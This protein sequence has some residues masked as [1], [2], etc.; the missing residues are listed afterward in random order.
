MLQRRSPKLLALTLA[1][2]SFACSATG[3]RGASYVIVDTAR[4]ERV[5]FDAF[6]DRIAGADVLFLGEQHDNRTCHELQHWTTIA[7]AKRKPVVLSLE[8]FESD[9]QVILDTYLAGGIT[10][11]GFLEVSRPW[12]NYTEHY[13]PTIEWARAEEV[14]VIAAN[15]PRHLAQKVSR[16]GWENLN[17]I[18]D[19]D[20]PWALTVDEPA[21]RAR[22][23]E[24]M[25]RHG[26]TE[27]ADLDDWFAAQCVKDDRMAESIADHLE[28]AGD[29]PPLVIHWCGRFHSDHRL[30]TV[31]RL[32]ARRPDLEILTVSMET[33]DDL[34]A[35]LPDE[36]ALS[37]DFVWW[38]R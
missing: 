34:A 11:A 38:I 12:S 20:S 7:L 36:V 19:R 28:A 9:V 26:D 16:G 10:E 17:V 18:G 30:G 6:I 14:P 32:A 29:A 15:I 35:P 22:F 23:D 8:Q 27:N 37:A 24:A 21:Y 2:C 25:G 1:A 33:T 31:S 5:E 4:A 3:P 13:R